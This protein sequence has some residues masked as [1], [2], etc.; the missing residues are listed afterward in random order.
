MSKRSFWLGRVPTFTQV[1]EVPGA[2]LNDLELVRVRSANVAFVEGGDRPQACRNRRRRRAARRVDPR[3]CHA[4]GNR[5]PFSLHPAARENCAAA[6]ISP[7]RK[8]EGLEPSGNRRELMSMRSMALFSDAIG[9][10]SGRR[11]HG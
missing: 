8:I 6:R 2:G 7:A 1:G 4:V 9:A 10:R 3:Q 11:R 5:V